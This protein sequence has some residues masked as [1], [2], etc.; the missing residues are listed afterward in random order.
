MSGHL[1]DQGAASSERKKSAT[2]SLK[3]SAMLH[4]VEQCHAR[5]IDGLLLASITFTHLISTKR[6]DLQYYSH[7]LQSME[8]DSVGESNEA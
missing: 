8:N 6:R 2:I 4:N 5:H 1:A 3:S 7:H